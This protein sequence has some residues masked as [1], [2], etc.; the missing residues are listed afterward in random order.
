MQLYIQRN[1]NDIF[2]LD[3]LQ[4]IE[5]PRDVIELM[6]HVSDEANTKK[7]KAINELEQNFNTERK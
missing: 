5:L 1:I 3:F 2:H 4:F 7:Q 6:L